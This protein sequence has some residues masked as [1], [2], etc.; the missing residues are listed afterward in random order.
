MI[1]HRLHHSENSFMHA[2]PYS[3][4][5]HYLW[6]HI[7]T[8]SLISP[9]KCSYRICTYHAHRTEYENL[10]A[11]DRSATSQNKNTRNESSQCHHS[12]KI[13]FLQ[14]TYL[15]TDFPQNSWTKNNEIYQRLHQKHSN[16]GEAGDI[17]ILEEDHQ[18][19]HPLCISSLFL[20]QRTEIPQ[21]EKAII[22]INEYLPSVSQENTC[23]FKLLKTATNVKSQITQEAEDIYQSYKRQTQEI[24]VRVNHTVSS[25]QDK[26][27]VI[28]CPAECTW[29]GHGNYSN[30][31]RF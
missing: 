16:W 31:Y 5:L 9:A 30:M 22:P 1:F 21:R 15:Q 11:E 20:Q 19:K 18:G 7:H 8:F 24:A 12:S 28:Q 2:V 29:C 4:L 6:S 26:L 25:T 14:N 23:S 13:P 27:V 10:W 17:H 3:V